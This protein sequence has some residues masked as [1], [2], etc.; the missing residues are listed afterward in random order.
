LINS[1][2]P[3]QVAA[4]DLGSNS[5]HLIVAELRANEI[6][7]L[8]R[9][10]E[11]VQLGAGL[12][13]ERH[14]TPEIQ[15]RALG[16]IER[17]GQRL[18][19]LPPGSV[20]AVGTNTLRAAH[21]AGPW[22]HE[23][24]KALGHPIEIISGIEEA[25][26]IY[27]GVSQSLPKDGKRRLIMDIGGGSTEYIIGID[28]TPLQKESL[29]MGCVAMSMAHFV[30]GKISAK[31][32][33][34][35][36]IAAERELEPYQHLFHSRQ[37]NQA[38]GASG[39]LRTA[40]KLLVA[41]GFSRD[42]ITAA[43][44]DQL[45]EVILT[46]GR[47]TRTDFPDL[48]PERFKSFPGG[49]AII[50]ATFELL[51][52]DRMIIADGALREGLLHDLLGRINHHDIRDRTVQALAHRY[53]VEAEHSRLIENTARRLLDQVTLP[54][55]LDLE[56][57]RQW[58]EWSAALHDIGR[59]IAHSGYHKHGAYILANADLPGFSR[60]DQ[61]L[62]A[63][64]VRS[65]RR[66]FP[67]RLFKELDAPWDECGPFMALI[68]RIAI[69][70]HRSRALTHSPPMSIRIDRHNILLR[71]PAGWLEDHPLT[72]ADL[73]LEAGYLAAEN[74]QLTYL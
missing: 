33:K 25:R 34:K 24:V 48:D 42:G 35:A 26:L 23:A 49:L 69:L 13:P 4:V 30:D 6:I 59:D 11:M 62:M 60:Q 70:V 66:K 61:L 47:M 65:Q 40:Q 28:E 10:R 54:P 5:F 64:L 1:K 63:T 43:G 20:R 37:W 73:E 14:L 68:L 27:Q 2:R 19:H 72:N 36:I 51:D 52:I 8:D 50:K 16:C 31:R 56:T 57:A 74:I 32:F 53:H 7:V 9:L 71:F 21:N 22:L 45:I 18:R 44:I 17:F 41:R 58:L 38:V 55:S 3:T 29:K 15:Q 12:T 39:T 67:A 46:A